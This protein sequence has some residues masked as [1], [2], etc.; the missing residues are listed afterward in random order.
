MVTVLVVDDD[1][2]IGQLMKI[3]L[4]IDGIEV[5]RASSGEA[6]LAL[7]QDRDAEPD[8]IVLDLMMPGM[9]G[10]EAFKEMRRAGVDSPILF[11]SAYGAQEA[12]KELGGQGAIDKPFHPEILL[13][14]IQELTNAGENA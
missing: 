11:C 2:A 4:A 5:Q 1:P 6:A 3:I 10:R 8:V 14:S 12:N 9:D 13:A 7:L